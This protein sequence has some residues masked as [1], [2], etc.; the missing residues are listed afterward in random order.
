MSK[1]LRTNVDAASLTKEQCHAPKTRRAFEE[2]AK[3]EVQVW[4]AFH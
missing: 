4:T 1:C 2:M 3:K